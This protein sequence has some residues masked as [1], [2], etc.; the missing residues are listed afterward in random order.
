MARWRTTLDEIGVNG[1]AQHISMQMRGTDHT[2][3]PTTARHLEKRVPGANMALLDTTGTEGVND[4]AGH[5]AVLGRADL[6][7]GVKPAVLSCLWR[8][9]L[10]SLASQSAIGFRK[11]RLRRE[12]TS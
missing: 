4:P 5:A 12:T 6:P 1:I 9:D 7:S 3:V 10:S 2:R 8:R 11:E